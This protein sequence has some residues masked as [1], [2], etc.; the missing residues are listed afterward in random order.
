VAGGGFT[1]AIATQQR[2]APGMSATATII[3]DQRTNVVMVPSKAVQTKNRQ[4]VVTV[5]NAD[6]S[7]TDM[8][9]TTGLSDST[10]TEITSGLTD[11]QSIEIPGAATTT[12]TNTQALPATGGGFGGFGGGGGGGGGSGV[13][14]GGD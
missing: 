1:Q 6:G 8:A 11:G 9:V 10:N 4:S 13:A 2:P 7:T 5:K 12:T 3:V 14:R